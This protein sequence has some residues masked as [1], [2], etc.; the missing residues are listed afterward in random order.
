MV[1][2]VVSSGW[3]VHEIGRWRC[4][5]EKNEWCAD[6]D[7]DDDGGDLYR[8]DERKSLT[9]LLNPHHDTHHL[10]SRNKQPVPGVC[11]DAVTSHGYRGGFKVQLMR[12]DVALAVAAA[13]AAH[14]RLVLGDAALETYEQA[15]KDPRCRDLDARV[16]YRWLG[17]VEPEPEPGV[18]V[19][20]GVGGE[21]GGEEGEGAEEEGK[22]EEE[23]ME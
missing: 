5:G 22:K 2:F 16:V 4:V 1:S 9:Q 13:Q 10:I 14:A 18:G 23:G 11:P 7:D 17:G 21:G 6:N 12:K 19:G 3:L 20:V 15:S 8:Y